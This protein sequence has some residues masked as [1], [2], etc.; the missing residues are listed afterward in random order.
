MIAGVA[1]GILDKSPLNRVKKSARQAGVSHGLGMLLFFIF[2]I[3][4][5]CWLR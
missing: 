5:I 3:S 1:P 2:A 4:S